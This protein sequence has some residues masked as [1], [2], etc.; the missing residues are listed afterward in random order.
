MLFL[1]K[2]SRTKIKTRDGQSNS[3]AGTGVRVLSEKKLFLGQKV[4]GYF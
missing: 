1:A 3:P 4:S 2:P